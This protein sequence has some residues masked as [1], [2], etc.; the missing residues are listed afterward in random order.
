MQSLHLLL[1]IC[2]LS[3]HLPPNTFATNDTDK[4]ALLSFKSLISNSPFGALSSGNDSHHYCQWQGVSCRNHHANR[5]TALSLG[6]LNLAG[7][8]SPYLANLTFLKS[9]NLSDNQLTG[10]IPAELGHLSVNNLV[11]NIP[12]TIEGYDCNLSF[13]L[14]YGMGGR[15]SVEG[16]VYSYGILVLEMFTGVNPIVERFKDRLNLNMHVEMAFSDRLT[17]IIDHEL[18]PVNNGGE[19][20]NVTE[21]VHDC[22]VSVIQCESPYTSTFLNFFRKNELSLFLLGETEINVIALSPRFGSP[23]DTL[24]FYFLELS[25]GCQACTEN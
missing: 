1:L 14:E 9:F 24:F 18:F 16:D 22:L 4:F 13:L 23:E 8:I 12:S 25:R 5:V 2:L 17:E 3:F 10:N 21:D 7:R 20:A 19:S 15:A 6:S 11:G